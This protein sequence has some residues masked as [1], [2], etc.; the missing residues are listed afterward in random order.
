[1]AIVIDSSFVSLPALFSALTVKLAV[2]AAVGVPLISPV[3]SF[4]VRPSGRAPPLML[5]VM[6]SVPS[7]VRAS[8]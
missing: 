7:A 8:L 4:S 6:G 5:H 2:P 1:M 3:V